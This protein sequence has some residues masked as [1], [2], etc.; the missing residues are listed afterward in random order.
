[1]LPGMRGMRLDRVFRHEVSVAEIDGLI[2]R[3]GTPRAPCWGSYRPGELCPC[4]GLEERKADAG[5]PE[6][7]G[8]GVRH[9]AARYI[10]TRALVSARSSTFTH[11]NVGDWTMGSATATFPSCIQPA[12][13]DLWLPGD[14]EAHVVNEAKRYGYQVDPVAHRAEFDLNLGYE[15]TRSAEL[16]EAPLSQRLL[17]PEVTSLISVTWFDRENHP[18][19]R[20]VTGRPGVDYRLRNG[21]VEFL[22]G[23]ERPNRGAGYVV[24]YKAPACY[25]VA[26]SQP[27]Y[28]NVIG[29]Q[30]PFKVTL[31]RLDKRSE[32]DVR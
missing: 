23:G 15:S 1:M 4:L 8:I 13:N 30:M 21:V 25:V 5:C 24:Q 9:P 27:A 32:Q 11:A 3:D 14:G 2:L 31:Q 26:A 10:K 19:R 6:C 12:T 29:N 16:P 18:E 20:V 28:R 17:Y 22:D 7:H